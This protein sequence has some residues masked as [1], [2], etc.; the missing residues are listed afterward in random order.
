[1]HAPRFAD[2]AEQE[3]SD[4][5][6]VAVLLSLPEDAAEE[7]LAECSDAM[8]STTPS[9]LTSGDRIMFTWNHVR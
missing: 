3:W 7:A 1:V 4:L 8:P 9:L 2:I 6:L 5:H